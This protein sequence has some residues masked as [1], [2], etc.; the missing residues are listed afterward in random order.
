MHGYQIMQELA[1]RTNGAWQPSPGSV[2]PALQQLAD[3]RLISSKDQDGRKIFQLTDEGR[4]VTSEAEKG[5]PPWERLAA[6]AGSVDLRQTVSSVAS[7][8][9][10][11]ATN[12]TPKQVETADEILTEAR[13]RLYQLLAE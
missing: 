3:E 13:K 9:K 6:N 2:Y 8:A 12:G 11:V 5:I 4:T 7:A 10:Q 1:E